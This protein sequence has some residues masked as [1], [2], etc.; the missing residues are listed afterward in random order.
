MIVKE[1]L[2]SF[3]FD[4]ERLDM[5][6]FFIT[7]EDLDEF[8]GGTDLINYHDTKKIVRKNFFKMNFLKPS[9]FYNDKIAESDKSIKIH[10]YKG[11]KGC[12]VFFNPNLIFH[13]G[14]VPDK[15]FNRTILSIT[16]SI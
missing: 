7:L 5:V 15:G 16:C 3:L 14:N 10:R 9:R 11:E 8:G 13:R 2:R 6:R 4:K 1:H 12:A